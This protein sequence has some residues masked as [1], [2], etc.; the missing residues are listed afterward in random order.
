MSSI[1]HWSGRGESFAGDIREARAELVGCNCC[2]D[3]VLRID[4]PETDCLA[5]PEYPGG[6]VQLNAN[7]LR[8][9]AKAAKR[10]AKHIERKAA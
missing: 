4:Y 10:A 1:F 2:R 3:A 5:E 8:A 9:L 6:L 7:Q